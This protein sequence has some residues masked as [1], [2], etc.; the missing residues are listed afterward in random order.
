MRGNWLTAIMACSA[1][2][3]IISCSSCAGGEAD[4]A[5]QPGPAGQVASGLSAALPSPSKVPAAYQDYL[6][7]PGDGYTA[8]GDLYHNVSP[9][10]DNAAEFAP[11]CDPA[12][13]DQAGLAWA[14]YSLA[15]VHAQ[16][17]ATLAWPQTGNDFQCYVGVS[18]FS[19]D[20]WN[21]RE[22]PESRI[23]TGLP[24]ASQLNGGDH[25]LLAV[26]VTG[27]AS[28]ALASI[29]LSQAAPATAGTNLFFLHH[30]TGSGIIYGGVRQY[31][32]DYNTAHGTSFEFW[33]HGYNDGSG[34]LHDADDNP[35]GCYWIPNDNTDPDGLNY[36]WTSAEPDAAACR[37]EILSHHDV[38]AFKSCFP[39]S[40]IGS[41]ADLQQRKDWYLAMR[42]VFETYSDHVF[43]VLSTPPLH[44]LATNA[45]DAA[46]A[47]QFA[48]WLKS[49]AYLDGHPNVV[50]YDL[51][52]ALAQA[53]DG[54]AAANMLRYD[55]EGR[56]DNDDSHPNSAANE[57]VA[58]L[59]AQCLID[60]SL[61]YS[62]P[63]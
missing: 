5:A 47:R 52:D 24:S 25:L 59:F 55:Y 41:A 10:A 30:S 63:E 62:W 17:Y 11:D 16:S 22:L 46:R 29:T 43:V 61:G 23:L 35:V 36:L 51:F 38:I 58:P 37:T 6:S 32:E 13:P 31:I 15:G 8:S 33:D 28:N 49:P 40:A 7:C 1:L 4:A 53:D 20:A 18:D 50:C 39:A 9:G 57:T 45:E 60:A 56:H 12:A 34:G 19:H 27:H 14:I 48:N 2:L 54:S 21:W 26:V 42:T 44:R 3:A